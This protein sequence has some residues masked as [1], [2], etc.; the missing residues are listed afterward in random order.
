MICH[1]DLVL[2]LKYTHDTEEVSSWVE[3]FTKHMGIL[4]QS[5]S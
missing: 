3:M 4:V 2:E 5:F 1:Y